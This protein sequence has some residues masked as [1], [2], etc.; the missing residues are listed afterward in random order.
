MSNT[1]HIEK[2][3]KGFRPR[4]GDAVSMRVSNLTRRLEIARQ[5]MDSKEEVQKAIMRRGKKKTRAEQE[6]DDLENQLIFLL[7]N[8]K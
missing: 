2:L 1:E 5:K 7:E 4:F 6:V 3:L 8:F